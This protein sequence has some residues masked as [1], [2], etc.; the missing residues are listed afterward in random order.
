MSSN[1]KQ[2]TSAEK[3]KIALEVIKGELT[4]SQISSKYEVHT[5]QINKWRNLAITSINEGFNKDPV[6]TYND[7]SELIAKLYQQIGELTTECGWLKKKSTVF[8]Y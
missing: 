3:T 1:R 7:N 5:T 6:K 4:L 8:K 2:Y